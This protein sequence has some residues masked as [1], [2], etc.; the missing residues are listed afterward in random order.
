[1]KNKNSQKFHKTGLNEGAGRFSEV[2]SKGP[3]VSTILISGIP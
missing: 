2:K 1:M 3:K